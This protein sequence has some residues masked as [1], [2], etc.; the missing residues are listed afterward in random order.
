MYINYFKGGRPASKLFD[1]VSRREYDKIGNSL[2]FMDLCWGEYDI[3]CKHRIRGN[4][5]IT[6]F[7]T[8]KNKRMGFPLYGEF[9]VYEKLGFHKD[10]CIASGGDD[11]IRI[12]SNR[13]EMMMPALTRLP[14]DIEEYLNL[15]AIDPRYL[16]HIQ[17]ELLVEEFQNN[18]NLLNDINKI[19]ELSL[20]RILAYHHADET[21]V[22][23]EVRLHDLYKKEVYNLMRIM[24]K[25]LKRAMRVSLR[26]PEKNLYIN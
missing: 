3:F 9:S 10:F 7:V 2:A 21:D 13:Y 24:E 11:L 5:T 8:G 1:T 17:T 18:R 6:D 25:D 16:L 22:R 4:D 20:S 15:L 26:Q 14:Q 23:E 19:V 12:N